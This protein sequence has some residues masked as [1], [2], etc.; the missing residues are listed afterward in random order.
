MDVKYMKNVI[1]QQI[2]ALICI[3]LLCGCKNPFVEG[4]LGPKANIDEEDFGGNSYT[5]INV[6]NSNWNSQIATITAPGNYVI[7]VTGDVVVTTNDVLNVTTPGILKVSIRGNHT[8][9]YTATL[10]RFI[11]VGA[12][13]TYILRSPLKGNTV[14]GFCL[15]Q[16][17]GGELVLRDHGSISGN[18]SGGVFVQSPGSSF[19][20]YGGTISGNTASSRGGGVCVWYNGT[21][22]MYGGT[23]SSNSDSGNGGGVYVNNNGV[24]NMHG[25]TI[26]GNNGGFGGGGV[27]VD[28]GGTFTMSGGTISG[29]SANTGGGV[30]GGAC[31]YFYQN[32]WNYLWQWRGGQQQYCNK[33]TW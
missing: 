16:V 22:T 7:N 29:N 9:T 32:R 27:Y 14:S 13:Q 17:N 2:K 26:S 20:M 11:S 1:K 23:I 25:G 6:D 12:D 28:S 10:L 18:N 30:F 24:F 33:W 5:E 15:V 3:L 21:F 19:T 31:W 8:I 4:I